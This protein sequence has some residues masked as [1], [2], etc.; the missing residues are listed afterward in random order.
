M[1]H[2][3][4]R[5][6]AVET[7]AIAYGPAAN[8]ALR[9]TIAA[10]KATDA[11]DPVTVLVP[12][13]YVSVSVR[14][15]LARPEN[16]PM[17]GG[18][19]LAGVTFATVLRIGE[20]LAAP[21]L[22]AAGRR[23]VSN[24]VVSSAV[25]RALADEPGIFGP[26][27]DHP[28]TEANLA[29][30]HRELRDLP[31][32]ALDTLAGTG[33]RAAEVVRVH[34]LVD[35][36]LRSDWYD[37]HDLLV[38]AAG[39]DR[40]AVD[41]L[42]HVVVHLPQRLDR[43]ETALLRYVADRRPCTVVAG[44]T[45]IDDADATVRRS[46]EALGGEWQDVAGAPPV[47]DLVVN[48]SDADDEVR[49][50]IRHVL[51]DLGAGVAYE[52]IAVVY[53]SHRPYARIVDEHL[54][55]AGIPRNGTSVRRLAETTVGRT[56]LD[57][58]ALPDHRFR[59]E[60]VTAWMAAAPIR[61]GRDLVPS[62][63]W[64]RLSRLAGVVDGDDWDLR[65]GRLAEESRAEAVAADVD[66]EQPDWRATRARRDA[67][68]A[69]QL[70]TFVETLRTDVADGA[71]RGSWAGMVGWLRG[72][73]DRYLGGERRRAGWPEDER[74]AADRVDQALDRLGGLDHIEPDPDIAV[75]RRA[76]ADELDATVGRVGRLGNGVLTGRPGVA[77][78]LD[79][80]RIYVL[81]VAEGE[82]P[83]RP[84]DDSLLPDRERALVGGMLPL[85]GDEAADEHRYFLAAMASAARRVVLWPRGDLRRNTER[86]PSRWVLASLS[87]HAGETVWS[88]AAG[89]ATIAGSEQVPSFAAGARDAVFAPTEQDHGIQL[90][91]N[92]VE[93]D[94]LA[95]GTP[96]RRGVEL[97]RAR[98]GRAFT[99]FDGNLSD[100]P[101]R[102]D[103]LDRTFSATRLQA[104]ATCPHAY[105]LE[106]ELGVDVIEN[107]EEV[108]ELSALDRG[109]IVHDVLDHYVR[110][111][112]D[113]T[114]MADLL[115]DACRHYVDTGRVGRDVLWRHAR[116]E[117][118]RDCDRF[119]A[120]D[121]ARMAERGLVVIDTELGF[122]LPGSEHAAVG[123]TLHDGRSVAF[124]G[125][126]DRLDESS[127]GL[128]VLDYKTGSPYPYRDD[129][130]DRG[131]PV[132]GGR[133]L[134]LPI[135]AHAARQIVGDPDR[136]VEAAYWFTSAKRGFI[137][138][139]YP[140]DEARWS[141]FVEALGVLIDHL[142]AGHY[143]ARHVETAY[144]V[145][146]RPS[147]YDNDG[148]GTRDRAREWDRKHGVPELT[149]YVELADGDLTDMPWADHG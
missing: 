105:L 107:P 119:A 76:L 110:D 46:V 8:A 66:P 74:A 134:Q 143:P 129:R 72:A 89:G 91:M 4:V 64:E 122:G 148:L 12:T 51:D 60:D 130:I 109:S 69:E 85:R 90:L 18:V 9:D 36:M 68:L 62:T 42:G 23:P 140:V 29:R 97:V 114:R 127:S 86:S 87:E 17:P 108:L 118:R 116:A 100:L 55:A 27:A 138:I 49:W 113:P 61:D 11:L 80:D 81:G 131:D 142:G 59:R 147:V 101:G 79:L 123:I 98:A 44:R 115:A 106:Y 39:A 10:A 37:E 63:A 84:G 145:R 92:G 22:A 126:I 6:P 3:T 34:R 141:R 117:L 139:G 40:P 32:A 24:A 38:A 88:G 25:R 13:N 54:D 70:A 128:V 48:T 31:P 5:F 50:V 16:S 57:L 136:P 135:Y 26:V 104:Y 99:R 103:P 21:T 96:M 56:A 125:S 20:L 137:T 124:R 52:R 65:L 95:D 146:G 133:H 102:T 15:W 144:P 47:A 14:R 111:G 58:L 1:S 71:G 120:E 45:G 112:S 53:G 67:D 83:P 77:V 149:S 28:T 121:A 2:P 43:A 75:L 73:L 94:A 7:V 132:G 35:S 33:S 41:R 93:P 30:A 82:M 78:G 19:G